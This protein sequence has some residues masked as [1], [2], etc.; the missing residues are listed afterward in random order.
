MTV[1]IRPIGPDDG[2]AAAQVFFDAVREGLRGHYT[3]AQR[4]ALSGEPPGPESWRDR[5]WGVEGF[6]AEQDG[7]LVGFMTLAGTGYIDLAFVAPE[8][9]GRGVGWQLYRA[10]EARAR[11]LGASAL[12][13]DASRMAR[14]FF[15]RQGWSVITEQTVVKRGVVLTNYLMRKT[16]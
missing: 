10:V 11:E 13:T 6:A 16:L 7:R 2:P 1:V 14:P 12:T 3:E 5:L 4:R 9:L 15:E 8:V